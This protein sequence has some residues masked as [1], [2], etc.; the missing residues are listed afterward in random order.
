MDCEY[1]LK[2]SSKVPAMKYQHEFH[3]GSPEEAGEVARQLI[4]FKQAQALLSSPSITVVIKGELYRQIQEI[5][6]SDF[7]PQ[8]R[9]AT[10][11][12]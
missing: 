3:A 6:G 4:Q 10:T 11:A 12:K 8:E 2:I 5:D 7:I 9:L 1:L